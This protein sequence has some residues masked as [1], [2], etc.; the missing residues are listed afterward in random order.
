MHLKM[1]LEHR[2]LENAIADE[3]AILGDKASS[4]SGQR[5]RIGKQSEATFVQP[6]IYL[7]FRELDV[8]F[9]KA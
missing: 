5:K 2:S 4:C 8:T 9:P 7:F 3:M 6:F 1:G